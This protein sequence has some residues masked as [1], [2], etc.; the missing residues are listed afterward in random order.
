MI[1]FFCNT[2]LLF[3][4]LCLTE[5]IQIFFSGKTSL[6]VKNSYSYLLTFPD[7]LRYLSCIELKFVIGC[8]G[9]LTNTHFYNKF[10][11]SCIRLSDDK[12][13]SFTK[14]WRWFFNIILI[15]LHKI[16]EINV[17]QIISRYLLKLSFVWSF[18]DKLMCP[19]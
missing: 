14:K 15:K 13:T 5:N 16:F 6:P 4:F 3:S 18:H 7:N 17:R 8:F 10:F 1:L 11:L 2:S 9:F 19:S 12:V